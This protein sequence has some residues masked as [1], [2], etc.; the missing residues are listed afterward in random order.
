MQEKAAISVSLLSPKANR[1][2][3]G[4]VSSALLL[5]LG[6]VFAFC[7]LSSMRNG[8]NSL[9]WQRVQ[10][11]VVS[12]Q[13]HSPSDGPDFASVR[14]RYSVGGGQYEGDNLC[15]GA[16]SEASCKLSNLATN[17]PVAVF[18]NPANPRESVLLPGT[19]RLAKAFLVAG[20]LMGT[21]GAILGVAALRAHETR[22]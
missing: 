4:L 20:A 15:F 1:R 13:W 21:V 12:L 3:V 22:G 9:H 19:S 6:G 14:Y 17:G 11:R 7:S 2:T 8:A 18:V 5:L 16:A 10:G